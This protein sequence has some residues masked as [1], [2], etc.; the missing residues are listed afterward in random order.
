MVL[1]NAVG[2]GDQSCFG[3]VISVSIKYLGGRVSRYTVD[4]DEDTRPGFGCKGFEFGLGTSELLTAITTLLYCS[5][6][7]VFNG[8]NNRIL[9]WLQRVTD[10]Q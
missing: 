7:P 3:E 5:L 4:T 2:H 10:G 6:Q 1:K 9:Q 8:I